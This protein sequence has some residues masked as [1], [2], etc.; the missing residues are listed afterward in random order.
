MT[1]PH[2][3]RLLENYGLDGKEAMVYLAGLELGSATVQ[4]LAR[5]SQIKRTTV[6]LITESLKAKGLFSEFKNPRGLQFMAIEPNRLLGMLDE[7]KASLQEFMPELLALANNQKKIKP[8]VRY[9]EGRE[10][11]RDIA[12]EILEVGD[13]ELLFIGSY[14]DVYTYLSPVFIDKFFRPERIRKNIYMR[15]LSTKDPRS[16]AL[17]P[18]DKGEMREIVFLPQ[19]TK[20]AAAQ[21]ICQDKIA[22]FSPRRETMGFIVESHDL[23]A[24][25]RQK[26]E[27]MWE[28]CK[29]FQKSGN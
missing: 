20:Y 26:F 8:C 25:E 29:K 6:Y 7:R 14:S 3:I 27:L 19:E 21:Y 16:M 13:T 15:A 1:A 22:N 4:Q 24:M 5:K 12:K 17:V 28:A 11:A 23:A 18:R 10:G 9:Y 2:L